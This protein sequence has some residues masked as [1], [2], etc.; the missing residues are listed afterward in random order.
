MEYTSTPGMIDDFIKSPV[1]ADFMAE[2]KIRISMLRDQLESTGW[3]ETIKM[4][5]DTKSITHDYKGKDYDIFRGGIE[6]M[7]QMEYIFQTIR[8]NISD[9]NEAQVEDE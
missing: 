5:D 6:N 4:G 7:R 1:Y 8:D 9:D 3:T 2:L